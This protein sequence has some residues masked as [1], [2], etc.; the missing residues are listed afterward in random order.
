MIIGRFCAKVWFKEDLLA[1]FL[2]SG[3]LDTER[4]RVKWWALLPSA[5]LKRSAFS[6]LRRLDGTGMFLPA[7]LRR[8]NRGPFARCIAR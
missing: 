4:T 6:A 5:P 1:A 2:T 3:V 8:V 7:M